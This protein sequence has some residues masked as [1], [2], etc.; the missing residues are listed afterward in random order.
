MVVTMYSMLYGAALE[1][2][3]GA[4]PMNPQR[5]TVTSAW[6]SWKLEKSMKW[7]KRTT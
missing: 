7:P 2:E 6:R 3:N 5:A 1:M 4:H